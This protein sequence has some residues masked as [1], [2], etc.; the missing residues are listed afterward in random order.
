MT[1]SQATAKLLAEIEKEQEAQVV[2]DYYCPDFQVCVAN[3]VLVVPTRLAK[4]F[5]KPNTEA[6]I[7]GARFAAW[8]L[9]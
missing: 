7:H 3:G 5:G 9:S 8:S 2:H 1:T 6:V 4:R